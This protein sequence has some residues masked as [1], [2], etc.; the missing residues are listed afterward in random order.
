MGC[1]NEEG[2]KGERQGWMN[3]WGVVRRWRDGGRGDG[4]EMRWGWDGM[5]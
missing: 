3:G 2:G 4:H 5:G 1:V